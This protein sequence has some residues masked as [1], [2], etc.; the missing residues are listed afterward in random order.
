LENTD[1][2]KE[3]PKFQGQAKVYDF[4]VD[5]PDI[6]DEVKKQVESMLSDV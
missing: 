3:P 5:R 2:F 4:I 1:E 6:F